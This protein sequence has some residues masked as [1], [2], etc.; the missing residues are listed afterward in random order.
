MRRNI[1]GY[2]KGTPLALSFVV[3]NGSS[4]APIENATVEI[5]HADAAGVYDGPLAH[6]G[7]TLAARLKGTLAVGVN[8]SA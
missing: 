1:K 5:W 3:V 7:S 2:R 8:P 4:S 6:R